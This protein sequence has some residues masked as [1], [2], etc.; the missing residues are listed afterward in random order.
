MTS[1]FLDFRSVRVNCPYAKHLMHMWPR[2]TY[3]RRYLSGHVG[4]SMPGAP[5]VIISIFPKVVC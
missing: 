3:C 2:P 4:A 1:C 5:E